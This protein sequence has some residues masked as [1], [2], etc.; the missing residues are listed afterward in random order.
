MLDATRPIYLRTTC[1]TPNFYYEAIQV[2]V[3]QTGNYTI[4]SESK[5]NTYGLLYTSH[6]DPNDPS[7]NLQLWNAHGCSHFQ[8]KI[9][10]QLQLNTIYI[11]VVT[12]AFSNVT[13]P[14]SILVSGPNNAFFE[15]LGE[16]IFT[17]LLRK[18]HSKLF[19]LLRKV[20][21]SSLL[22]IQ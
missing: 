13:G 10:A 17:I 8:F 11:L 9:Q 19:V 15:H 22:Q 16:Y 4:V 20:A 1:G 3:N 21:R 14:F 5:I 6:F 2:I 12:T 18:G 7:V